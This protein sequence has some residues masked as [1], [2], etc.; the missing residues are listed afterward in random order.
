VALKVLPFAAA[1][2][3]KHLQRF[4]NE[5]L[6]AAHLHHTNIV[7]VINVG[8][9]RGVHY[10][11][12]QY[13]EG[14]TL[15]ALIRD[16]RR[17]LGLE[18]DGPARPAGSAGDGGAY[19][20]TT[21]TAGYGA[22]PASAHSPAPLAA[23][24][25]GADTARPLSSEQSNRD[26]SFFRSVARLGVQAA[27]ALEHAH[28]LGVIH[29]DIKPANL[30]V[31]LHGK[32]WVTDFGLAHCQS[33]VGLTM[34]GDL[35]GTLRYMSPEQ[36]LAQ[37]VLVDHRTDI[38]SLGI[39]LYELV[40]LE[41]AFSGRDRQELLRQIAFEE[42][43]PLR[44]LNG[45]V[46]VELETIVLKAMEK[47]PGERYATAQELA[48]DLERF[49]NDEPVRAQRPTLWQRTR[50]WARRHKPVVVTAGVATT[51]LLMM[52][53]IALTI[54]YTY[55]SEERD[56]K[57]KA[58]QQ[59]EASLQLARKAV[60]EL[61]EEFADKVA[62]FPQL[63]HLER[64]FWLKALDF[65]HELAQQKSAD[66]AIRLGTAEAYRR[67][68]LVRF[69]FDQY[70]Q[71]EEAFTQA[72]G[73]L[74]PLAAAYPREAAYQAELAFAHFDLGLVL[75]ETKK[76]REAEQAMRGAIRLLGPLASAY[77][78]RRSYRKALAAA[79]NRLGALLHDRSVQAEKAHAEAIRLCQQL[80]AD[81]PKDPQYRS[82]LFRGH[83]GLGLLRA[84]RG[85]LQEAEDPLRKAIAVFTEASIAPR[86][87]DYHLLPTAY[88]ELAKI[89]DARKRSQ[90]AATTYLK[91]I[92][93]LEKC[94][95]DFPRIPGYRYL[96]FDG[97]TSLA[98]LEARTGAADKATGVYRRAFKVYEHLAARLPA[99]DPDDLGMPRIALKL[100]YVLRA[101]WRLEGREQGYRRILEF[102]E[103]WAEQFPKVLG[104]RFL[105][106]FWQKTLANH[107]SAVKRNPQ[108]GDAYRQAVSHY[109]A[110]L[111]LNP[112]H[113][114]SLNN[115][116]W[117]LA[118]CPD[119]QVRDATRSLKLAHRAVELQPRAD[120]IWNTLG[121]AH[122][123]AG[124]W[125]ASILALEKSMQLAAG[126]IEGAR[127]ESFQA[128]FLALAH[129]QQ[130]DK[131]QA[132]RWYDRAI[133]WMD[134]YRP[135]DPELQ[136]FRAEAAGVMAR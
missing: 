26:T 115:L 78:E 120:H 101:D 33:Q 20:C 38:Y 3:A 21:L 136:C 60:D 63:E 37:R 13:I 85:Q 53:V 66:P 27:E 99:E 57:E 92:D 52:A 62:D 123:R 107:L 61:W 119:A 105:A 12:M 69:R 113:I 81:N 41:P 114:A 24:S 80:V 77:P 82:E 124:D 95:V 89:L 127:Q 128:F 43:R 74:E 49:L 59:A 79:S 86:A 18:S 103:N 116:A 64:Q 94:V 121:L 91:A 7:P 68:G 65:Y 22:G 100:A 73:I 28:Q 72:I 106:G 134:K 126:K 35:V 1:L 23:P 50:K 16:L 5:A 10:Y 36:A 25:S 98:H 4:K 70:Q 19:L 14:Q 112:N 15:A 11:A 58:L 34:S 132:G 130:G 56:R 54:G 30:L 8:C 75:T 44:R 45:K 90:E 87:F 76:V 67:V 29:R 9:E 48:D 31:D 104:C 71:A 6:A 17:Q 102:S 118:T 32:L 39:T 83:Y 135:H 93:I 111:K 125:R 108:A 2:D 42:P 109:G 88:L 96:L 117:L 97:Y 110:A 122:Y 55:V 40:A 129:W 46:P 131:E 133:A 51:V 84:K 47:N